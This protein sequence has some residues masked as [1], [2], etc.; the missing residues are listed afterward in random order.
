MTDTTPVDVRARVAQIVAKRTIWHGPDAAELNEQDAYVLAGEILVELAR[1]RSLPPGGVDGEQ[2]KNALNAVIEHYGLPDKE[3][4]D[5][6]S[7]EYHPKIAALVSL[8]WQPAPDEPGLRVAPAIA[9][10][11][12][13]P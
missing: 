13:T 4:G 7:L 6:F 2:L 5:T 1:L 11:E 8:F 12:A 3:R 10:A 9:K